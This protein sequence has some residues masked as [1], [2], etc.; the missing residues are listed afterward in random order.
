MATGDILAQAFELLE[1][2]PFNVGDKEL[3]RE[4]ADLGDQ[5][6]RGVLS[7]SDVGQA[8][9]DRICAH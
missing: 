9:R 1:G 6:R 3:G 2:T 7:M 4:A 8:I 5:L